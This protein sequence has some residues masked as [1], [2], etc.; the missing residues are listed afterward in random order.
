M[1]GIEECSVLHV[2]MD[3]FFASVEILDNPELAGKA[4]IV[5]GSGT[6]G[7][8][9]SCTYEARAYGIRS[10]MPSVEARRRCPHAVFLP[11]RYWR[12]SEMSEDLHGILKEFTPL[13]EGIGLDE[14]FLDV[15]GA[16]RLLGDPFR[17][18]VSIRERVIDR[19]SINCSIGV[20]RTKMLAKL[21]S[22]AAK[23]RAS[24]SGTVP[25]AGV[26]V[27][28]PS[29]ETDFLRPLP[30]RS[31]W[32]VGPATARRLDGVGIATVGELADTSVEVLCRLLGNAHGRHLAL[33]ARGED[34]STVKAGRAV[35]SVSH[36]E[37]F[38]KDVTDREELKRH[39]L[40]MSDA[41]GARLVE[42]KLWGRTVNVK[43][44]FADRETITRSHTAG[45]ALRTAHAISTVAQALVAATDLPLGVRLVGVGVSGLEKADRVSARQLSFAEL[46]DPG[47]AAEAAT[48]E[49]DDAWRH[50]QEALSSI[51]AR[52]GQGSVGPAALVGP[53]G[54]EAKA[55]GDTQWGPEAG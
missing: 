4:L 26:C 38:A 43:I 6:R 52:Y 41:V 39:V 25:G 13:V 23:P 49:E 33:L 44:R 19:M 5:G 48:D 42:S 28:L 45:G 35:K 34:E 14:A 12:Y 22:R 18:A 11:G 20:G 16:A 15:K 50:V 3:S 30:V 8:V 53:K 9:A 32:G 21:G 46:E 2:D 54:L 7:V 10:A 17:I 55:R 27:I 51:R 36:E 31:I 47:E 40:R 37:T 24:L 29:E 1:S